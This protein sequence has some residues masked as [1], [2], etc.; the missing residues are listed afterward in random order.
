MSGKYEVSCAELDFLVELS[1]K[2]PQI[3]GARMMGGGF[4]G[5]TLNLIHRNAIDSFVD[6]ASKQYKGK[7]GIELSYFQTILGQGTS[8]ISKS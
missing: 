8:L 1:K 2:E 6:R 7:F 5:C 4:G 3:L